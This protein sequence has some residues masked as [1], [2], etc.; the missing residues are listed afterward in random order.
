MSMS[1]L[2]CTQ[3]QL[4]RLHRVDSN[5]QFC[6]TTY[7]RASKTRVNMASRMKRQTFDTFYIIWYVVRN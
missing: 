2:V 1:M 5:K 6:Q 3:N 7:G 4:L